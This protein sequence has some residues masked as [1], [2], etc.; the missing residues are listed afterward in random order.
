MLHR[1]YKFFLVALIEPFKDNRQIQKYKRRS[2][3]QYTNYNSNDQ[4]W[5]F[6]QDGIHVGVV[7]DSEQQLTLQLTLSK[8]HHLLV[9]IVYA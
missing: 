6:I 8:G 2:D 7:S 4:I 9:T 3:M 1:H 5:V